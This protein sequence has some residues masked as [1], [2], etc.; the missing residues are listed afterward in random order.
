MDSR[1][2]N[3]RFVKGALR[4]TNY[5]WSVGQSLMIKFDIDLRILRYRRMS[6]RLLIIS[7]VVF[8]RTFCA[9]DHFRIYLS[10]FDA[11]PVV[12]PHTNSHTVTLPGCQQAGFVVVA[13][14]VVAAHALYSLPHSKMRFDSSGLVVVCTLVTTVVLGS[15]SWTN[16]TTARTESLWPSTTTALH[17]RGRALSFGT[18][19]TSLLSTSSRLV[20][21]AKAVPLSFDKR[22]GLF[23]A[24]T[25]RVTL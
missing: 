21:A 10:H 13:V 17:N 2:S 3:V 14:V 19:C 8:R 25:L 18:Y 9:H 1:G 12:F 23:V 4:P 11:T 5:P 22:F 16:L 7:V 6:F 15:L 20:S 24:H